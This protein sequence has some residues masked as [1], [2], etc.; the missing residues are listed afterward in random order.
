[1]PADL[2]STLLSQGGSYT[3]PKLHTVKAGAAWAALEYAKFLAVDDEGNIKSKDI[4]TD[5]RIVPASIN[6]TEKSRF[7]SKAVFHI[8]QPFSVDEYTQEFLSASAAQP[9]DALR[10]GSDAAGYLSA[11]LT[12][13]IGQGAGS[14]NEGGESN[15]KAYTRSQCSHRSP[16]RKATSLRR[17]SRRLQA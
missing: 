11:P 13:G 17:R 4:K 12:P 1:M 14:D 16:R 5:V 9:H 6:Y 10:P 2:L 15:T 7:R 3:E 8:G